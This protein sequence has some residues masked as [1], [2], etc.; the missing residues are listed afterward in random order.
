MQILP[1]AHTLHLHFKPCLQLCLNTHPTKNAQVRP[2]TDAFLTQV[3]PS[4]DEPRLI[5]CYRSQSGSY[6]LRFTPFLAVDVRSCEIYAN[7][8][9]VVT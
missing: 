7:V 2:D 8:P 9:H 5:A 3:A 1:F 6:T 4:E